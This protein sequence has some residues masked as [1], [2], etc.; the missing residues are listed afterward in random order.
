MIQF[1]IVKVSFG[2]IVHTLDFLD[3]HHTRQSSFQCQLHILIA[4]TIIMFRDNFELVQFFGSEG[5]T[6][7]GQ[8]VN[9]VSI[10]IG[11]IIDIFFGINGSSGKEA[12]LVHQRPFIGILN[13]HGRRRIALGRIIRLQQH[14]GVTGEGFDINGPDHA[15]GS[16]EEKVIT[17]LGVESLFRV[18][19]DKKE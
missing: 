18:C 8:H 14:Q 3:R 7:K 9:G 16:C 13:Q 17:A 2:Q 19:V 1:E 10:K 4:D 6:Q 12:E 15:H 11:L 5:W